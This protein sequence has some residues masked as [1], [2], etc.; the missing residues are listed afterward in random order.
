MKDKVNFSHYDGK[1]FNAENFKYINDPIAV[2][3]DSIAILVGDYES[4][5]KQ[6]AMLL[7]KAL[8]KDEFL[9]D[10]LKDV[11]NKKAERAKKSCE[12]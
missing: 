10:L 3:V 11:E 1:V 7:L 9:K 6:A 5:R 2:I 8:L 4:D 12:V